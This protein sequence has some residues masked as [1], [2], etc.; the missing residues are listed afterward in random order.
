MRPVAVPRLG[1]MDG[2]L[3]MSVIDRPLLPPLVDLSDPQVQA[4]RARQHSVALRGGWFWLSCPLCGT[5]FGGQEWLRGDAN[6]VAHIPGDKP[7][8]YTGICPWC[9]QAG[10]GWGWP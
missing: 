3:G 8:S 1:G 2:E 9:T 5:W 7:G 6:L 4:E 10:R